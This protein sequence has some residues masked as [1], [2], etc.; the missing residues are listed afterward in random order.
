M[1]RLVK[2]INSVLLKRFIMLEQGGYS[3]TEQ[4]IGMDS[5]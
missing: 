5:A 3:I 1:M 4:N 2:K